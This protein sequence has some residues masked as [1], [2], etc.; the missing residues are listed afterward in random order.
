VSRIDGMPDIEFIRAGTLDDRGRLKPT[1]E[2]YARSAQPWMPPIPG[3]ER[4]DTVP[5]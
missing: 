5:T 3:A 1:V 2:F 4:L